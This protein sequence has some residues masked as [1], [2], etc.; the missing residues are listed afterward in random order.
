MSSDAPGLCADSVRGATIRT[1]TRPMGYG[2]AMGPQIEVPGFRRGYSYSL[3]RT[4]L[5]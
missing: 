5:M 4:G 3:A 1:V 2:T